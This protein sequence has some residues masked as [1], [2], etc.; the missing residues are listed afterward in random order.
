MEVLIKSRFVCLVR[1]YFIFYKRC[2]LGP[3]FTSTKMGQIFGV[4]FV[5]FSQFFF[6]LNGFDFVLQIARR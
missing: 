4:D 5:Y 1:L 3:W 2:I 6:L